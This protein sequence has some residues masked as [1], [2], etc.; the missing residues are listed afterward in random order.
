MYSPSFD[1][2]FS[3][4]K[5]H[6]IPV[7]K[8][9]VLKE[10]AVWRENVLTLLRDHSFYIMIGNWRRGRRQGVD[11]LKLKERFLKIPFRKLTF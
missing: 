9:C 7:L 10:Y 5:I 4:I 11:D 2:N 1:N 6:I 3:S 8:R